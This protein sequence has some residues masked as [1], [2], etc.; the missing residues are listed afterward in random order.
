MVIVP[1]AEDVTFFVPL[2]LMV[3]EATFCAVMISYGKLPLLFAAVKELWT[4]A[5]TVLGVTSTVEREK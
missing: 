4:A 3:C 1:D 5:E 2:P